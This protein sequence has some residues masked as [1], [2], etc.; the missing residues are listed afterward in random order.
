MPV[1]C[2]HTV[3]LSLPPGASWEALGD[4]LMQAASN[5][6]E[7]DALSDLALVRLDAANARLLISARDADVIAAALKS[8]LGPWLAAHGFEPEHERGEVLAS[9]Q[10]TRSD[11]L[12][13]FDGLD[14][15]ARRTH[16]VQA[17]VA[18]DQV[19]SLYADTWAR[20]PTSD[21]TEALPFWPDRRNAAR[22]I[23][24]AWSTFAPRSIDLDAFLE[25]W[26]TGMHEDNI[27]AVL[28]PTPNHPG[29]AIPAKAL[30]A[31]V[32]QAR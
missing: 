2:Q 25:Q 16:F 31:E 23:T 28:H 19:W 18:A 4:D 32:L 6:P 7:A 30:M 8:R 12:S 27:L 13:R 24:G 15:A 14:D 1:G 3:R 26:L 22:C 29:T 11:A 10:S 5:W 21:E 17:V 20:A 9:L